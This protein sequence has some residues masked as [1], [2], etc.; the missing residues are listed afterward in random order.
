MPHLKVL[1]WEA[2]APMWAKG[3]MVATVSY[4]RLNKPYR[5]AV[6]AQKLRDVFAQPPGPV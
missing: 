1:G 6:L 3:D 2:T 5:K 4:H